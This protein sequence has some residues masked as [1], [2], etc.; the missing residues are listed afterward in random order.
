MCRE[1]CSAGNPI[2]LMHKTSL[3]EWH[4]LC[5]R[6][7]AIWKVGSETLQLQICC[8]LHS[9]LDSVCRAIRQCQS[10]SNR[11]TPFRHVASLSKS[12]NQ[13]DSLKHPNNGVASR[14]EER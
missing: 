8:C 3:D 5:S 4:R 2:V 1:R 6:C 12:I 7:N 10:V 11:S 14:S 9:D 13:L